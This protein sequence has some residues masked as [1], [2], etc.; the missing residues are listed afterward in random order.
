MPTKFRTHGPTPMDAKALRTH[1]VSVRLNQAE[2]AQIAIEVTQKLEEVHN[3]TLTLGLN[4]ANENWQKISRVRGR[5]TLKKGEIELGIRTGHQ[6]PKIN[7]A[8]KLGKHLI[9]VEYSLA[10]FKTENE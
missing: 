6:S 5:K 1:T 4:G 7:H 2:L 10:S 3:L 8:K 9:L